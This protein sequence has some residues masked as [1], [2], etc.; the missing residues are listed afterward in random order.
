MS[1]PNAGKQ[2]IYETVEKT[3]I[4]ATGAL[5]GTYMR[6]PI[7]ADLFQN[8]TVT[9]HPLGGCGM[10]EDAAHGVVDQA[11][12]VFSGMDG[13]AVHEGL[14]VMDGAVMPLSLGVNPC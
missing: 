4:E 8:R 14:Y 6:N 5:G 10:A 2:P 11:G 9:V 3:L 13:N 1:W 7:S 12:R